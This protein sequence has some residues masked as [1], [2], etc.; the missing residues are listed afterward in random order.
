M[1]GYGKLRRLSSAF[2]LIELLVVIAII[3]ILAAMLLPAL[4]RARENAKSAACANHLKQLGLAVWMYAAE[5]EVYPPG[6]TGPSDFTFF[7]SPYLGATA[8]TYGEEDKRSRVVE[9]PSRTIRASSLTAT[10]AAHPRVMVH[11]AYGETPLKVAALRRPTE[12]LIVADAMQFPNGSALATLVDTAGI[13]TDG[14]AV[15]AENA[16]PVGLDMDGVTTGVGDVR[17]R[18]GVRANLLFGDGH[19]GL[20]RKGELREKNIKINY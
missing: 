17:Y 15:N 19:V 10:Y 3:A 4:S 1:V 8:L 9:C 20:I 14:L 18:H 11:T 12:I 6:Y 5:F 16:V 13:S 7:L 2:T